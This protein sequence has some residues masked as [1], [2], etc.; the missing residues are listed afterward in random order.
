MNAGDWKDALIIC[1]FVVLLAGVSNDLSLIWFWEYR[2][3]VESKKK[4][5]MESYHS[6][7][8]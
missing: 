8:S 5:K 6:K 1:D 2:R 7:A 4:K 3:I